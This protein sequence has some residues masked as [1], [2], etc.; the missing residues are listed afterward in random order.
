M[1]LVTLCRQLP[2]AP[3]CCPVETTL[4]FSPGQLEAELLTP[5]GFSAK[6]KKGPFQPQPSS[7]RRGNS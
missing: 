7:C 2:G 3:S 4:G 6:R 1:C 5:W